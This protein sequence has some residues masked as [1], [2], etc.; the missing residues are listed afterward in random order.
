MT[1]EKRIKMVLP[2]AEFIGTLIEWAEDE[3]QKAQDRHGEPKPGPGERGT[4]PLWNSFSLLKADGNETLRLE[5]LYRAHCR[6]ILER[7]AKGQDTRPGTDAEL[8]VL[9]HEASLVAPM[10]SGAECLYFRLL[11]RSVPELARAAAPKID[12]GAYEK[13]HGRAAD[14]FEAELR[15]RLRRDDRKK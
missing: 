4:G 13:V 8:I 5:P 2:D 10:T 14:D 11:D 3:I 1:V 6:E 7:V 12:L 9:I 15:H